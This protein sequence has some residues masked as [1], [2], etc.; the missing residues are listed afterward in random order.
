MWSDQY[1]YYQIR[2][3]EKYSMQLPTA[4]IVKALIGSGKLGK[5]GPQTFV[6]KDGVPGLQVCCV[7]SSQGNFGSD[8]SLNSEYC[9]LIAV[10]AARAKPSDAMTH[11]EFLSKISR[12]LG[13]QLILEQ[14]DDGNENVILH[15]PVL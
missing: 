2:S 10:V 3:D 1:L 6:N 7:N 5:T 14:D 12:E 15:V 13:W 8:A 9:N 4:T 11:V